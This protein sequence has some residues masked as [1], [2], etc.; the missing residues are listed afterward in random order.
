MSTLQFI[1]ATDFMDGLSLRE[2]IQDC[3]P[4]PEQALAGF[5]FQVTL[6]LSHLHKAAHMCHRDL[7]PSN[8]LLSSSGVVKVTDLGQSR[9]LN[10]TLD[11][12]GTYV[13]AQ[14]YMSP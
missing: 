10:A 5:T 11:M 8:L 4:I 7:K 3:T 2:Y 1:I 9:Q 6:A 12:M 13:G 14:V